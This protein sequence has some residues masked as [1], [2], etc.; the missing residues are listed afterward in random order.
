MLKCEILDAID[1]ATEQSELCVL[2]SVVAT[3]VKALEILEYSDSLGYDMIIQESE[4]DDTKSS[5]GIVRKLIRAI[6]EFFKKMGRSIS[7]LF[8][9]MKDSV[10]DRL[11]KL[12]KNTSNKDIDIPDEVQDKVD[13]IS[14]KKSKSINEK[15]K[16][17]LTDNQTDEKKENSDKEDKKSKT[18][19]STIVVKE[20]KIK[21]RIKFDGWIKYL[22]VV[23]GELDRFIN[24]KLQTKKDP[25]MFSIY[26]FFSHKYPI[27][28]VADYVDKITDL[29]KRVNLKLDTAIKKM[30]EITAV[31]DNV[32]DATKRLNGGKEIG[33]YY[34]H[35]LQER[36]NVKASLKAFSSCLT[37]YTISVSNMTAVLAD[38]L[39]LY[40]LILD[41]VEPVI[42]KNRVAVNKDENN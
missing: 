30:D 19:N 18:K 24:N 36:R 3:Y 31:F 2:E 38:E 9:K 7:T 4:T 28:E 13:D 26:T 6:V 20:R 27:S 42:E 32:T 25:L 1:Y 23:E 29:M 39:G 10:T 15:I 14:E 5:D 11:R 16:P 17:D 21:T 22:E 37:E 8:N 41:V 12:D 35:E 34:E 33:G 40:G